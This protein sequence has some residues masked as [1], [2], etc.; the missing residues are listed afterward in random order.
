MG[1]RPGVSLSINMPLLTEL[2]AFRLNLVMI[3]EMRWALIT[4]GLIPLSDGG[5]HFENIRHFFSIEIPDPSAIRIAKGQARKLS[6]THQCQPA[7]RGRGSILVYGE[8]FGL[9]INIHTDV[10]R[11]NRA[12]LRC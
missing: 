8:G 4:S 6:A 7:L 5:H 1:T 11:E 3:Q 9:D 10:Y 12:T 2:G